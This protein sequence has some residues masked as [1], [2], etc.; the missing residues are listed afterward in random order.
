MRNEIPFS[1]KDRKPEFDHFLSCIFVRKLLQEKDEM[2]SSW[3]A[4]CIHFLLFSVKVKLHGTE[5]PYQ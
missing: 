3:V 5:D 1:L 2:S 4:S